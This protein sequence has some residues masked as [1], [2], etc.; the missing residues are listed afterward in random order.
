[1]TANP[2]LTIIVQRFQRPELLQRAAALV[3]AIHQGNRVLDFYESQDMH[4][5]A[6]D[7]RQRLDMRRDELVQVRAALERNRIQ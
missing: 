3:K 4:Q 5:E 2:K 6:A 7:L 1:M